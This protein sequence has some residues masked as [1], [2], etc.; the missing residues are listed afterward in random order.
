M[1]P[2]VQSTRAGYSSLAAA[3]AAAM[4]KQLGVGKEARARWSI[5]AEIDDVQ[6]RET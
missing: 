5:H 3:A 1:E 2:W 4:A 6:D